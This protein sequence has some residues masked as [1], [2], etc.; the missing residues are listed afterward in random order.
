MSLNP[1]LDKYQIGI[2]IGTVFSHWSPAEDKRSLYSPCPF[3]CRVAA[4]SKYLQSHYV[5]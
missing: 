1:K 3:V 4:W 2:G 5:P